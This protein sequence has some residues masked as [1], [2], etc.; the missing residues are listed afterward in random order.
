MLLWGGYPNTITLLLIPLTFYLFLQ[1]DRFSTAPFLASTSLLAG[2]I[3]LTHSLSAAIFVGVTAATVLFVLISPRTFVTSRK[4][5]FYWLLPIVLGAVLVAPF[6]LQAVPASL[7]A[8]SSFTNS[9]G[10]KAIESAL[11][12]T[13]ILPLEMILP[14]FGILAAFFVFSKRFNGRVLTLPVFLLA[15]WLFVPIILT[16]GYLAG[17]YIDYN[18]FLYFLILPA[19]IFIAVLIEYGADFFSRIITTYRT[20]T[21][22]TLQ[23]TQKVGNEKIARLSAVLT[24]KRLYSFFIIFFL[25][26]SFLTLPIFMG[27]I[28]NVGET[29]QSF[30][31][32][33]NN[34]E[35]D[36]IQ[37][38]KANTPTNS[39]FVSDALYG[40]WFG[41]FA[42]RRTISAVDPQ[43]LS[44]DEEFN[45]TQFARSLLDT[46]FLID[47]GL[48][49]V[50]EDG[51]YI[52]RHNPEILAD[53]NWTYFPFSFFTFASNETQIR[54]EVNGIL[55]SVNLDELAVKNMQMD[56]DSQHVT[57]TVVRGNDYF[58]YTQFTTVYKGIRFVNLTSTV[59]SSVPGVSL[60]W[61]DINVQSMGTQIPYND[62]STI[63]M[64]D[65]GVK[66]FGQLIFNTKTYRQSVLP[67]VPARIH[68]E[69]RLNGD[70]RGEIQISTSAYSADNNPNIYSDLTKKEAFFA[71]I[72]SINLGPQ[73]PDPAKDW[74]QVFNYRKDMQSNDVSYV[75][76]R[77]PEFSVIYPKF[78]KD[79]MFSLVFI[80]AEVAIFRVNGNFNQDG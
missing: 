1:R 45:K 27:P 38:A 64:L 55:E 18:R 66:T 40:W 26:L 56:T 67:G 15:M 7:N 2:S 17:F 8:N 49:Q 28:Y 44:I 21:R 53:L 71:K 57:I 22:Q 58:N 37:W 33:M 75:A 9:V 73:L 74:I 61:V 4:T 68:L 60:D 72:M 78:L 11:L 52:A 70:S 77:L 79:P 48:V 5:G 34:P 12:S 65:E 41:G 16:Q 32:V 46:D 50:R 23:A 29:I 13:R 39:V 36:A 25:L 43:Y 51:G 31:Q 3:F 14:M 76:C 69:Y 10:S 35:W 19:V 54:Y 30:Y 20:L 6:L 59:D 63:G 42:Q 24:N 80:N 47:N 62:N